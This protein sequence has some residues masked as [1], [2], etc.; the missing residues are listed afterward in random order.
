MIVAA[1]LIDFRRREEL[2]TSYDSGKK[3]IHT[4]IVF[5]MKDGITYGKRPRSYGM[6]RHEDV[7]GNVVC[8][9]LSPFSLTIS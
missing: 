5:H 9:S 6:Y 2:A 3:S 7:I 4:I 8:H 1:Y